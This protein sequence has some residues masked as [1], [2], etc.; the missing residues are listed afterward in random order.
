MAFVL[1]IIRI[2]KCCCCHYDWGIWLLP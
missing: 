1:K 2:K